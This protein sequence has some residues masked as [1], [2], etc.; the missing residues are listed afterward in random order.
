MSGLANKILFPNF[1]NYICKFKIF[2]L[3]ETFL[4][5]NFERY[6]RFFKGFTLLWI[7]A[8]RTSRFG[9]ASGGALYGICKNINIEIQINFFKIM[10]KDIVVVKTT[11]SQ[12]YIMPNYLNC[13]K[14]EEDYEKYNRFVQENNLQNILVIGD[15]NVRIGEN[16]E[17][18]SEIAELN[19]HLT[20]TR[21]SKDKVVN[22]KGRRFL[23]S[24]NEAGL[25]ILNGRAQGDYEG[26]FTYVDNTGSSVNDLCGVSYGML[27]QVGELVV[28]K[29]IYSDH[30]PLKLIVNV[31]GYQS[32]EEMKL[33][34]KLI[35][36]KQNKETYKKKLEQNIQTRMEKDSNQN[37]T[38]ENI[39]NMIKEVVGVPKPIKKDTFKQK[40][41]DAACLRARNNAFKW[42]NLWRKKSSIIARD[43][44]LRA[45]KQYKVLCALKRKTYYQELSLKLKNVKCTKDWWDLVNVLRTKKFLKGS[46]IKSNEFKYHFQSLLNPTL[47]AST[48][49]EELGTYNINSQLD[50][51]ITDLEIWAVL[52]KAKENKAAGCDRVPYEFFINAP[53]CVIDLLGKLFNKMLNEGR[54]EASFKKTLIFP[55]HKKGNVNLV[56]NYRGISFMDAIAKI[57]AG[58]LLKRMQKWEKR[59]KILNEFQAGFREGYSTVDNIFNLFNILKIKFNERK[60]IYCFFIDF[61][62]AFDTIGRN[63]LFYKLQRMGISAKFLKVIKEL[64]ENTEAAVWDG[65]N[66]S[67]WFTTSMGV[68]QGC[69][70]SP[71]LFALFINDMHEYIGG[72]ITL[73]DLTI[74][75]LM[76]ADD[77]VIFAESPEQ[78]QEMINKV[79]EYCEK[80]N[81]TINLEK[82]KV[83][84]FRNNGG[85]R[86]QKENWMLNEEQ[87]E[88][89]NK[90][91]YLGVWL[92]PGLSLAEHF[93]ERTQQAKTSLNLTWHKFISKKDMDI[94]AKIELFNAVAR[95]ILGY[96]AQIWGYQ[97]YDEIEKVQRFFFKKIL[98]LPLITPSYMLTLE[99]EMKPLFEFTLKCHMNY[100]KKIL[101]YYEN[102]RLPQ[103][104]AKKVIENKLYWYKQW[105]ELD[106]LGGRQVEDIFFYR[107]H[108]SFRRFV[109]ESS[110]EIISTDKAT[111][112][113]RA[114]DSSSH[115]F[116]NCLDYESGAR[117][118]K[119]ETN[120]SVIRWIFKARGGLI[121][122]NATF[123]T[124]GRNTNCTL[125]NLREDETFVHFLGVCPVLNELRRQCFGSRTLTTGDMKKYLNGE[126]GG[127]KSLTYFLAGAIQYRAEL[128]REFNG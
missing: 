66:L 48:I 108:S 65:E 31:N 126:E 41:F 98:G 43:I 84:I 52:G 61:K 51:E 104:L 123:G 39:T 97:Q 85:R 114:R 78:L 99:C 3:Y 111:A 62:A 115:G 86:S 92:T 93:K 30:M 55:I 33:L 109:E 40:W 54:V 24:C 80:W 58:V 34:P 46:D 47:N 110:L 72:G 21:K 128:I 83:M 117:Y 2:F 32:N 76:Y 35:W 12:F 113:Q 17:I 45:N 95:A 6:E 23:E 91:K 122:L 42:L 105:R 15:F 10:E 53:P 11:Q 68:K 14:W 9:R 102:Y 27:G 49:N 74:R 37:W 8:V 90:Y 57:F 36:M 1:F 70:L 94:P 125:C 44:Y 63:A 101:H 127:W 60:K 106:T 79:Q 13:N 38:A 19:C 16:Q 87:I 22:K 67:E 28:E 59:N 4:E 121:L 112:L 81:L 26:N 82:S 5:E 69:L 118:F 96:G 100:I 18:G 119:K 89:V 56:Q 88:V 64:Y 75:M 103:I 71:L 7:P 120:L 20:Q 124:P 25:V 50:G 77:I 116:Y 107:E 73:D 29:Q